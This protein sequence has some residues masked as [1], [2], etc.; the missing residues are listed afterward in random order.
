MLFAFSQEE[1]V[2]DS[3]PKFQSATVINQPHLI[4]PS[5]F[6]DSFSPEGLS[7]FEPF[8]FNQPLLP[9][10]NQNLDFLKFSGALKVEGVPYFISGFGYSPFLS[11]GKIF[12]RATYRVNDRLSLGGNSFGSQSVFDLPR[13]N[14]SIQ[15]MSTKGASMFLQ[16]KV[17]KNFKVEGRVSIS[18]RPN[19]LEP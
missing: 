4:K 19:H 2:L 5:A 1:I 12:N 17:S 8:R 14:P 15:D 6:D 10:Y 3:I 16:Y 7:L 13:I 11:A 9:D 18:N